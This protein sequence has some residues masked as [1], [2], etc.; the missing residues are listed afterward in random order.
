MNA[1]TQRVFFFCFYSG[2]R[3]FVEM[4]D[5]LRFLLMLE[6]LKYYIKKYIFKRN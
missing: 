4:K 2:K 6:K 1:V 5:K 3:S